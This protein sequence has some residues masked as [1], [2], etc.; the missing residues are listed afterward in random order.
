MRRAYSVTATAWL[1]EMNWKTYA[2][3]RGQP[4]TQS[5]ARTKPMQA[6][7]QTNSSSPTVTYSTISPRSAAFNFMFFESVCE[8]SP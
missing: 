2:Q 1:H 4:P 3:P 6:H 8:V 7:K 5:C